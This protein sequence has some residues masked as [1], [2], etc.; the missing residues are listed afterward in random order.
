MQF[1][2]CAYVVTSTQFTVT[3]TEMSFSQQYSNYIGKN[4]QNYLICN[5]VY[6]IK[7][8]AMFKTGSGLQTT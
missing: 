1:V 8:T 5:D 2:V 4:C 7:E 3:E 6:K